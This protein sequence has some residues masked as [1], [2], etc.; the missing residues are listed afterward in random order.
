MGKHRAGTDRAQQ[1]ERTRERLIEVAST[2]FSLDGFTAT[3]I[4]AIADAAGVTK[5][6]LYHHFTDKR[7]LYAACFVAAHDRLDELINGADVEV[8]GLD[9]FDRFVAGC[10]AFLRS[11]LNEPWVVAIT[12]AEGPV[13]LGPTEWAALDTEY[14]WSTMGQHLFRMQERGHVR[15]DVD[16]FTTTAVLNAAINEAALRI[17]RADAPEP[18]F[19]RVSATLVAFLAGLRA[20]R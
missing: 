16:V 12:V 10:L 1:A 8:S 5:G 11:V 9:R 20:P 19:E 14:A 6:A 4:D 15:S 3:S 13:A 18:E 17:V 2:M 7:S